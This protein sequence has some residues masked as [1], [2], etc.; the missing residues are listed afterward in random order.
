MGSM[1]SGG[2][3]AEV[4]LEA[5]KMISRSIDG[6]SLETLER[7]HELLEAH[8]FAVT[9]ASGRENAAEQRVLGILWAEVEVARD[10]RRKQH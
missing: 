4:L 9:E 6:A 8:F 1:S 5:I 10:Q 7:T 2:F 3:T